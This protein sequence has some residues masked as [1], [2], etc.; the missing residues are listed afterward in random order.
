[1]FIP[2]TNYIVYITGHLFV[3]EGQKKSIQTCSYE[4]IIKAL[5]RLL[6]WI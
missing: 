5:D 3:R 4:R 1:M 6:G 2:N